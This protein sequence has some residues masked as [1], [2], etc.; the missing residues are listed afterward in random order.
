[1][2]RR[3]AFAPVLCLAL[4]SP[5]TAFAQ[6]RQAEAE[7]LFEEGRALVAKKDYE[8]AC[9][10]FAES[11]RLE[12][13]LGTLTNLAACQEQLGKTATAWASYREVIA[14][15]TR[16]G[17]AK[18]LK[19]AREHAEALEKK[20]S[21]LTVVVA[22]ESKVP[23]LEITRDGNPVGAASWG[24]AIAVDPGE[25]IVDA[26]AEGRQPFSTK[27][28][29]GAVADQQTV[30]IPALAP[31]Q[32]TTAKPE[33]PVAPPK[34][35]NDDRGPEPRAIV[36]WSGVIAGGAL[37]VASGVFGLL[38]SNKNDNAAAHCP[39]DNACDRDGV[40][41]TSSAKDLATTST[42]LAIVGGVV[43]VGGVAAL[44][45]WPKRTVTPAMRIA[46]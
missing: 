24:T 46:F 40:T 38:A 19:F 8:E 44:L 14:T 6:G 41:L 17:D 35:T 39:T 31:A 20:L 27:V 18:R 23:G 9:P 42:T 15:A 37:I 22:E 33:N 5:T 30:R 4:L 2:R 11:Y 16:T 21:R 45:F 32:P 7:S 36:G 29:I 26:H 1:V 43:L 13:G 34:T 28:T 3:R 25:H 10:K 12:P